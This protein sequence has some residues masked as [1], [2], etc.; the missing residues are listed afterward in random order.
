MVDF[1]FHIVRQTDFVSLS[2]RSSLDD[3][4]ELWA[5]RVQTKHPSRHAF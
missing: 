2:Q 5:K 1:I 4:L 3:E